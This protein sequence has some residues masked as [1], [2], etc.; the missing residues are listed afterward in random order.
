MSILQARQGRKDHPLILAVESYCSS[1]Q[2]GQLSAIKQSCKHQAVSQQL[3]RG[4]IHLNT[5]STAPLCTKQDMKETTSHIV[6]EMKRESST[7]M[8][9]TCGLRY[10][11]L[12]VLSFKGALP[13]PSTTR[14]RNKKNDVYPKNQTCSCK[15]QTT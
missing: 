9:T 5:G 1:Q 11:L 8:H 7:I 13:D 6:K 14:K 3:S 10:V 12:H 4:K 15:P 2:C